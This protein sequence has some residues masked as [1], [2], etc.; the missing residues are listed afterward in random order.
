MEELLQ[1]RLDTIFELNKHDRNVQYLKQ[2]GLNDINLFTKEIML[3]Y[4]KESD[5]SAKNRNL[6]S[7]IYFNLYRT[8]QA[9]KEIEE[10]KANEIVNQI[11]ACPEGGEGEII[12]VK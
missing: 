3:I 6:M 4:S 7:R 2:L 11:E 1:Q 8:I 9:Q 5:L 12:K 10:K